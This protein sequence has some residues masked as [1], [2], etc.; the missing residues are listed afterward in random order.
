MLRLLLFFLLLASLEAKEIYPQ[1]KFKAIGYVSDFIVADNHLYA[2]SD[3]GVVTVFDLTTKKIVDTIMLQ[4]VT[5]TLGE[6]QAARL[7]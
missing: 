6:L 5:T 1:H 2:A 7:S 4:P 3:E